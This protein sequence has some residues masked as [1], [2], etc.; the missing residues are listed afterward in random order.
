MNGRLQVR[1]SFLVLHARLGGSLRLVLILSD[2]AEPGV[3]DFDHP[4]FCSI[5]FR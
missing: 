1:F 3:L 2:L 5:K 4:E